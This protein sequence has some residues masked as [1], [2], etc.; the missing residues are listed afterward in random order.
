[1][2]YLWFQTLSKMNSL[3]YRSTVF[4]FFLFRAVVY[5]S[6]DWCYWIY[7]Y[8]MKL[9]PTTIYWKGSCNN[10]VMSCSIYFGITFVVLKK[11]LFNNDVVA[12]FWY[13]L[14]WSSSACG[15]QR[16]IAAV[17][18]TLKLHHKNCSRV[19]LLQKMCLNCAKVNKV[20][21]LI[22]Q[23]CSNICSWCRV[24][25]SSSSRNNSFWLITSLQWCSRSVAVAAGN[26]N[27]ASALNEV[28]IWQLCMVKD[29]HGGGGG[30]FGFKSVWW[31]LPGTCLSDHSPP[32]FP[33]AIRPPDPRDRHIRQH[34]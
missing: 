29:I 18:V 1:M 19:T 5:W 32:W 27:A 28:V 30:G 25:S 12:S 4:A 24:I 21:F 15:C 31:S 10:C 33:L 13:Y 9:L 23:Y 22:F 7:T 16:S 14:A 2:I 17:F 20:L 34:W 8:F 11:V 6:V 3:F 26:D